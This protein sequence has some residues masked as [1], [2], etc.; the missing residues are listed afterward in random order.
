[1]PAKRAIETVLNIDYICF[2]N[3]TPYCF[4]G[5]ELDSNLT[6]T[7]LNS[8]KAKATNPHWVRFIS[9]GLS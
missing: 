5:A 8:E 9:I 3:P 1:M 7:Y 4:N 2:S 6:S